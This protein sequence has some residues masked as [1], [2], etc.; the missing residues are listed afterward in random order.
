M[1]PPAEQ[2]YSTYFRIFSIL[3]EMSGIRDPRTSS[4]T[5]RDHWEPCQ[6]CDKDIWLRREVS[7]FISFCRDSDLRLEAAYNLKHQ[8]LVV[9]V[10]LTDW[11]KSPTDN[12]IKSK[13]QLNKY[14]CFLLHYIHKIWCSVDF[15]SPKFSKS[16]KRGTSPSEFLTSN[17]FL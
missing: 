4:E 2:N 3:K 9:T 13:F 12:F 16:S 7:P 14:K 1:H 6:Q 10:G 17:F 8:D 5:I 15:K 11:V